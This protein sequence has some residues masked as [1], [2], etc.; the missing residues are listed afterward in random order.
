MIAETFAKV[1]DLYGV[2]SS[3]AI[4]NEENI[5]DLSVIFGQTTASKNGSS[6]KNPCIKIGLCEYIPD[7]F[8]W[9]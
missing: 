5:N 1:K 6:L 7:D 4:W 3:F 2:Y 9:F 8:G